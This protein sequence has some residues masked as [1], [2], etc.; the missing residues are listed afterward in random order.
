MAPG[1]GLE[2]TLM[3]LETIALAIELSGYTW[4]VSL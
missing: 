2:P 1:V 4:F 3:V